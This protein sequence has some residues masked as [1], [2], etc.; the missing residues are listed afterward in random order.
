MENL[1]LK[2]MQ[3]RFSDPHNIPAKASYPFLTVSREFGCPSKLISQKLV[4][5]LNQKPGKDSVDKWQY[6]NKEIV[7]ES[8][9]KLE[10]NP[11]KIKY[12]FDAKHKGFL[13]DVLSS[14]SSAYTSSTRVKKTIPEVIS[15]FTRRG[16][17]ILVGRGGVAITHGFPNSLHIRLQAP[18][19]WRVQEISSNRNITQNQAARM[20][21][22]TDQ[23]RIALIEMLLCRKFDNSLFD[24]IINCKTFSHAE[25]IRTIMDVMESRGMI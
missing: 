20:I 15:S 5:S 25:I 6:I 13:D 21:A 16:H 3:D 19:E 24:L 8:A 17:I 7:E 22:E 2:Y 14:F 10:T 23:K 9:R 18:M 1:L 12:F 11:S 4:E